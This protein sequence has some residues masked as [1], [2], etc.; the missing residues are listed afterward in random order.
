MYMQMISIGGA[1][2]KQRAQ[3]VNDSWVLT[4]N[5]LLIGVGLGVLEI[6]VLGRL[7][8]K[9]RRICCRG[10]NVIANDLHLLPCRCTG[11]LTTA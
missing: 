1:Q 8:H 5:A 2:C 11:V 9:R 6:R 7:E 4:D 10:G 3:V